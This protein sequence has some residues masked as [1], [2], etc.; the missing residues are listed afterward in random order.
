MAQTQQKE[1]IHRVLEEAGRPLTRE[2][3]LQLGRR[4]H[5]RLGS[6]TVN[7]V[8]RELTEN[9]Q[10]VGVAFPGQPRRYELPATREHPHFICRRC[11][12]VF[13]L[14][15]TV[16]LPPAKAPKGFLVTGGEI[17]YS[18]CCPGCAAKLPDI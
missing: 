11:N 13:D 4:K 10:V 14:P 16:H 8:I 9:G 3:I 2:E 1:V 17:I 7:R 6:A 5:A 15:G 12:R 18:G